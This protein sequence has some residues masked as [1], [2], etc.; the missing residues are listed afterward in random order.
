MKYATKKEVDD[1]RDSLLKLT[2]QVN[3]IA[4]WQAYYAIKRNPNIFSE[5]QR[6][7]II[8]LAKGHITFPLFIQ[9]FKEYPI[10]G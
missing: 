7:E 4:K 2:Q 1:I 3:E 8:E 9:L 10:R 5:E 6:K